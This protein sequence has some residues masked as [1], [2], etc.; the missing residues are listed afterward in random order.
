MDAITMAKIRIRIS[1]IERLRAGIEEEKI[2]YRN[3]LAR[4]KSKPKCQHHLEDIEWA[5]TEIDE[6]KDQVK[7]LYSKIGD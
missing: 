7:V 2:L 5:E 3:C 6:L 4:R 1:K